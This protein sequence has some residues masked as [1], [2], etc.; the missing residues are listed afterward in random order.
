MSI[1]EKSQ[2]NGASGSLAIWVG[3]GGCVAAL[4]SACAG[5]DGTELDVGTAAAPPSDRSAEL[6]IDIS[7]SQQLHGT[8]SEAGQTLEFDLRQDGHGQEVALTG[9]D[10][11]VLLR[12][13]R[14]SGLERLQFGGFEVHGP[15]GSLLSAWQA[16]E[17]TQSSGDAQS[18]TDALTRPELALAPE[19]MARL[20]ARSDVDPR[21]L[22]Q[23]RLN[24]QPEAVGTSELGQAQQALSSTSCPGSFLNFLFNTCAPAAQAPDIFP[25]GFLF[26]SD[27][28]AYDTCI[29]V[30]LPPWCSACT[31]THF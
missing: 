10:G 11:T 4:A 17:R 14:S 20:Q 22:D 15:T 9:Q 7:T 12:A 30:H 2:W 6:W 24:P 5:A 25:C 13:I 1:H 18:G 3:V 16:L 21:L 19:L 26:A 8:F 29:K 27:P 28:V 23:L 31:F